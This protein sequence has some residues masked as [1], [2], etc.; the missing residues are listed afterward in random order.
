MPL[1][2]RDPGHIRP[3][4]EVGLGAKPCLPGMDSWFPASFL[5][6]DWQTLNGLGHCQI[7][8]LEMNKMRKSCK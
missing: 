1:L 2:I 3:G 7:S 8:G 6:A 4:P 5:P